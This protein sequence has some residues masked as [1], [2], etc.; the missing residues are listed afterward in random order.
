MIDA[1]AAGLTTDPDKSRYYA[2]D[3][4]YRETVQQLEGWDPAERRRLLQTHSY[5]LFKPEALVARKVEPALRYL[6]ER[7]IEANFAAPLTFNRSMLRSLWWYQLNAAP[8]TIARACDLLIND[9]EMLLIGFVDTKA[10]PDG[11]PLDSGARRLSD[12]KGSSRDIGKGL[13]LLRDELGCTTTCLNFIH[14]PDEPAD[15]VREI[16]VLFDRAARQSVFASMGEQQNVQSAVEAAYALYDEDDLELEPSLERLRIAAGP[17]HQEIMSN[18]GKAVASSEDDYD[19]RLTLVEWLCDTDL[20]SRWDRAV[21]AAH[22]TGMERADIMP[23]IGP[24]PGI[25]QEFRKAEVAQKQARI[26][27]RSRGSDR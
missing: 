13:G 22:L 12:L 23:M 25:R 8:L 5:L 21:I 4:Y 17:G 6:A 26:A 2:Q 3:I 14:A 27:A 16:G 20:V 11:G 10:D 7:G 9:W 1:Y 18:I 15:V 24:P 19:D